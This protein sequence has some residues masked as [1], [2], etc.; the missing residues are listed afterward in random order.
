MHMYISFW[1]GLG[2]MPRLL[3]TGQLKL[4]LSLS[5]FPYASRSKFHVAVPIAFSSR[6]VVALVNVVCTLAYAQAAAMPNVSH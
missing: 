5:C 6:P 3:K 1:N 2:N 4:V